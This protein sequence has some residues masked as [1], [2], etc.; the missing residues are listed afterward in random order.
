MQP[1]R[2][3]ASA[4]R[5]SSAPAGLGAG[6]RLAD[7]GPFTLYASYITRGDERQSLDGIRASVEATGQVT[8]RTTA[9]RVIGG[10]IV[11]GAPGAI[12]GAIA[13]KRQDERE[14]YVHVEGPDFYW[15]E[16]IDPKLGAEARQFV[17]E[18]QTAAHWEW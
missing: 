4:P 2:F 16:S 8:K 10:M 14:L 13:R 1:E 5:P 6:N 12:V 18:I 9:T 17:A 11:G 3:S 15:V 7:L